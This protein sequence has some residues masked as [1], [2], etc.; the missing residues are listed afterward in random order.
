MAADPRSVTVILVPLAEWRDGTGDPG[1][2]PLP[3]LGER[4]F[5]APWLDDQ[6]A[7]A[8]LADCGVYVLTP[9]RTLSVTMLRLAVARLAGHPPTSTPSPGE[10]D[11]P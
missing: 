2:E 11:A 5:V 3:N 1:G 8:R 7:G 10:S 6:R 9:R 4:A